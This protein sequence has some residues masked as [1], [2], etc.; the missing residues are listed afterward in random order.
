MLVHEALSREIIGAAMAV[1][2]ELGPGLKEKLYERALILEL[3]A[4]NITAETQQEY[5]VYYRGQL[6]GKLI[7]D[8]VVASKVIVDT[9]VIEAFHDIH[10]A[11]MIGYLT[12]TKLELGLIINF[13]GPKLEWKRVVRTVTQ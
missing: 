13:K 5:P 4:R 12:I 6:I 9:K 10:F 3:S 7:P 8:L 1:L 2:N 11:Q